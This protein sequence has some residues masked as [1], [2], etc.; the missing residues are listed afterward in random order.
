MKISRRNFLKVLGSATMAGALAACGGSSS[1]SAA[2]SG[3]ASTAATAAPG[4]TYTMNIG[5]VMSASHP[6]IVALQSFEK[7]VEERTN[8]RDLH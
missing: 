3:A 5:S 2:V 6:S 8:G 4:T 1:T 7:A